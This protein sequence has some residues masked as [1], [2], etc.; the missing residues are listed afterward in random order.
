MASKEEIAE[1]L[2]DQLDTDM[3]WDR[4]LKD[5][6]ELLLHLV[7]SG[8]L[9][10]PIIKSMVKDKGRKQVDQMIDEWYPGKYARRIM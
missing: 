8:A 2:N 7:E 6:L 1:Q 10:E 9:A 3:E 5:D 4:M